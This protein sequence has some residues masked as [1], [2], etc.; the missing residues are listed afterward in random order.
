[1]LRGALLLALNDLRQTA[2][3]RPSLF[4]MVIMPIGFIFLFGQMGGGGG[5]VRVGLTVIDEDQSFLSQTFA[6][7][8]SREGFS[9]QR[10]GPA[11]RDSLE[12]VRRSVTIPA[13][14]EDSLMHGR[15]TPIYYYVDPDAGSKASMTA[16]MHVR[17]GIFNTLF[18]LTEANPPGKTW[19]GP[20]DSAYRERLAEITGRTR[21]IRVAAETAGRGRPV[22][23]G[24]RQSLPATIALFMLINTTIY[25]AVFIAAEKQE[26]ILARIA[27]QPLS[28]EAIL[29]GKVLGALAI[30]LV[31]A[32]ILM[33]AGRFLLGAYLGNSLPGLLLVVVCFGLVAAAMALFWG[34]ILRR[35]EQVTATTLVVALFLGAIG[36]CWWPLE[37]VPEWMRTLG[38]IS[39]AAWAMDAFHALISFGAGFGAVLWP[40][41][42]LLGYALVFFGLGARLLRFSE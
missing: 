7:T 10:A 23:A 39:P 1:M 34:A 4:W 21:L 12:R 2:K 15:T 28:R 17:R 5:G 38:H 22:P 16:E 18:A 29:G 6:E 33:L 26:G 24:M 36:G 8:L 41:V 42:I 3:D 30:G 13:G 20:T 11:W 14:F 35:P 25:G 37:V 31:Q 40:C 27:S 9:I 19:A 32:G